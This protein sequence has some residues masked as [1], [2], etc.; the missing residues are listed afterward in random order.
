MT[1]K[2]TL[3]LTILIVFSLFFVSSPFVNAEE[4]TVAGAGPYSDDGGFLQWIL[5]SPFLWVIMALLAAV[6]TTVYLK[7][8]K[9]G[10]AI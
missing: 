4:A 10:T 9:R 5:S 3:K 1:Y 6:I 8:R 2:N 7:K